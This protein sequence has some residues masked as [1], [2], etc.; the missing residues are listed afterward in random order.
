MKVEEI[1]NLE[2]PSSALVDSEHA[3]E[4]PVLE[5]SMPIPLVHEEIAGS[6]E[7][8]QI[9]EHPI[10]VQEGLD[11]GLKMGSRFYNCF[12]VIGDP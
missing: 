8:L 11:V 3:K 10:V 12:R 4:V 2:V 9:V 1:V 6:T 7:D 5:V